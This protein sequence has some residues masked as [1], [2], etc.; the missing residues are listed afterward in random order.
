VFDS[1]IQSCCLEKLGLACYL[2]YLIYQ[3]RK[4]REARAAEEGWTVVV[5]HKGRKK[6]TD[7]E[8]GTAVGSVSLAAMQEKMANKKPKDVAP[9]FY[10]FHKREARLSGM[11]TLFKMVPFLLYYF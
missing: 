3:E 2:T 7:A 4:E 11:S 9:N 6:T 8:T 10:R 1:E 5:Q